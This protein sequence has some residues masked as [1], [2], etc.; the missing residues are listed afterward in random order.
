MFAPDMPVL[1][2]PALEIPHNISEPEHCIS[3]L[4]EPF[5]PGDTALLPKILQHF[6]AMASGIIDEVKSWNRATKYFLAD[7]LPGLPFGGGNTSTRGSVH[8]R[9]RLK[10]ADVGRVWRRWIS[11]NR[12]GKWIGSGTSR[13]WHLLSFHHILMIMSM[14]PV[15]FTSKVFERHNS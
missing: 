11:S 8:V 15:V 9:T 7:R 14:V 12:M 6:L 3:S 13:L 4:L 10:S 5:E 1:E 2:K